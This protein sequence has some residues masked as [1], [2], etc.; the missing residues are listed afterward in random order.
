MKDRKRD[1]NKTYTDEQKAEIERL[2]SKGVGDTEI[3]RRIGLPYHVIHP[4]TTK[5]WSDKMKNKTQENDG[6][7]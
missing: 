4:I 3:S 6:I 5:Y 7:K 1:F 2:G